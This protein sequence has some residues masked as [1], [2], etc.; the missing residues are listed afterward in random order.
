MQSVRG[1]AQASCSGP[2]TA[3]NFIQIFAVFEITAST[4]TARPTASK[5]TSLQSP[6]KLSTSDGCAITGCTYSV[7]SKNDVPRV[8][9][10]VSSDAPRKIP[11]VGPMNVTPSVI[12]TAAFHALVMEHV[13]P[14][15]PSSDVYAT[16]LEV[17]ITKIVKCAFNMEI[18]EELRR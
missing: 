12:P 14:K 5:W 10:S 13:T 11:I 1:W 3:S 7:S 6:T 8:V 2:L 17:N 9:C 15:L 18:S 4:A 16:K